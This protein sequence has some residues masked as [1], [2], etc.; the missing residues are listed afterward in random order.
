MINLIYT[1]EPNT[2]SKN[3]IFLSGPTHRILSDNLN[4]EDIKSWRSKAIEELEKLGFDGDIFIPEWRKN[5]KPETWTHSRQIDWELK[6]LNKST[7]IM[8]WIPR[9]MKDL[10][11]L[12]TNLEFGE[13]L[14]SGKI[15]CG[16]PSDAERN[17]YLIERCNRQ[18][19]KWH[20]EIS[21]ICKDALQL[22]KSKSEYIPKIF[23]TSDTHFSDPR[24]LLFSRR[25]FSSVEE[26]DYELVKR[27]NMIVNEKD[28]VYH[29]GDFGNPKFI[30]MLNGSRIYLVPGNYDTEF[31][32]NE[33]KKDN[34]IEILLKGGVRI[35]DFYIRH[36]PIGLLN[37]LVGDDTFYLYGHVHKL[38]MVKKNGLNVGVDCHNFTPI[39]YDEVLF[40]KNAILKHYD[41]NVFVNEM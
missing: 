2:N 21:E 8:F 10:P 23:F 31:F 33:L 15:A 18:N 5:I 12:I 13:W 28:I 41:Q 26:M 20:T 1:L 35:K 3:S 40:F 34:R 30:K 9:N 16:A 22:I 7:V 25:P 37:H 24:T 38:S 19:V 39:S 36:E 27:W 32:I 11:G 17:D 4:P 29:L 6:Y 14:K